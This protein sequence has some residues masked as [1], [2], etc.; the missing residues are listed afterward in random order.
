MNTD[1]NPSPK[2]EDLKQVNG[3]VETFKPTTL[4]QIWGDTGSSKYGTLSLQEYEL[5]LKG[6]NKT[7]L[8]A[9]ARKLGIMPNENYEL[10]VRKLK[11]EFTLFTN[12]YRMP[13]QSNLGSQAKITPE[14]AKILAEGR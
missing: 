10:L 14:I 5:Q 13:A 12:G 7:D 9:H 2:L 8:H 11:Q 1:N 6:M 3:K 4:A